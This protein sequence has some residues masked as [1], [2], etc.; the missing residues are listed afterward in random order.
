MSRLENRVGRPGEFRGDFT[1]DTFDAAKQYS[2]VFMQQGR[3]SIDADWNEQISISNHYQRMF[4]SAVIGPHAAPWN[5]PSDFMLKLLDNKQFQVNRGIYFVNGLMCVNDNREY[6]GDLAKLLQCEDHDLELGSYVIYLDAWESHVT[7]IDDDGIRE[8]ALGGADTAT[9]AQINWK[10]RARKISEFGDLSS[11]LHFDTNGSPTGIDQAGFLTLI[12]D[13]MKPGKGRML[14]RG[15]PARKDSDLCSSDSSVGYR[16]KE[17]QLYRVEICRGGKDEVTFK[18]SRENSAIMFPIR[19]ISNDTIMLE[20]LGRDICACLKVNDWVEVIAGGQDCHGDQCV[21]YQVVSINE[22]KYSIS[23][24]HNVVGD[25]DDT[26]LEK[27]HLRR[28]DHS[29]G[30]EKGIPLNQALSEWYELEDGV[31]IAFARNPSEVPTDSASEKVHLEEQ[32]KMRERENADRESAEQDKKVAYQPGDYWLIPARSTSNSIEWPM[33][34][35]K[36]EPLAPHGVVH[37]YAPLRLIVRDDGE[38]KVNLDTRRVISQNWHPVSKDRA[39]DR[40]PERKK[41][42]ADSSPA[43]VA[44]PAAIRKKKVA[45]KTKRKVQ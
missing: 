44:K 41:P 2:R 30:D 23:L 6:T 40:R 43:K 5:C 31:E 10:I 36:P 32:A 27:A 29:E 4:T 33:K 22:E 12:R 13:E 19:S 35:G 34:S 15:K 21:L 14:A 16:G 37:H 9:R 1:R 7:Y 24:N 20:H 18:W 17:N 28:W 38:E 26:A 11:I 25:F 39:T 45:K 3:V 8:Q 42:G